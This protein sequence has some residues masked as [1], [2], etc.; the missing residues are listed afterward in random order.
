[1]NN[2][3]KTLLT[4]ALVVTSLSGST[5]DK[6]AARVIT[7][8][9]AT[10]IRSGAGSYVQE[11]LNDNTAS[12]SPLID[13]K[14]AL[15]SLRD[16]GLPI[17]AISAAT[18][19]ERKTVYSWMNGADIRMPNLVRLEK[20]YALLNE[21]KQASF[22]SLY[23]LWKREVDGESL[24]RLLSADDL[25]S[26]KIA[27]LLAHLWPMA[28]RYDALP[29]SNPQKYGDGNSALNELEQAFISTKTS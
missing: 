24:E 16:N 7:R 8:Q 12:T 20:V 9:L 3:F 15:T 27:A 21:S 14:E 1:M 2:A 17:S 6:Y 22:K 13:H 26:S 25:D 18:Q 4:G 19:V 29:A 5:H 28:Q 23:R 10:E 11:N